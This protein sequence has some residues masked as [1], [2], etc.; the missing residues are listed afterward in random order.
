MKFL[1]ANLLSD[2]GPIF[3]YPILL[4]LLACLLILVFSVLKG[5]TQGKL[6]KTGKS[7]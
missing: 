2:G 5:D 7:S 3:M 6:K 4:L 1:I